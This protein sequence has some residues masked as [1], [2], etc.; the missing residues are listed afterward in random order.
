MIKKI[1]WIP[2]DVIDSYAY[3]AIDFFPK[4]FEMSYHDVLVTDESSVY[5][6]DFELTS[7][8]I[9]HKTAP[10]IDK[11]KEIYGVDV[12]GM[13]KLLLVDIFKKIAENKKDPCT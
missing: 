3:I 7:D 12:I 10:V 13:N 4:I 2:H 5:D 6:F 9:V 1:K 11:I 8:T